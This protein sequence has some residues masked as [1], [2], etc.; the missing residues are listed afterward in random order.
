MTSHRFYHYWL[1]IDGFSKLV[2]DSWNE[3]PVDISN[4]IRNFMKKLHYLKNKIQEWN[5]ANKSSSVNEMT[6]L[7]KDLHI[8]DEVIDNGKGSEAIISKRL[9]VIDSIQR[10]NQRSSAELAQK[11]KIQWSVEGDENS[12][13]FHG[14][15][16]KKRSQMSIRGVMTD[17]VWIDNPELVKREFLH[18]FSNRF[19]EPSNR[20]MHLDMS[21]PCSISLEQQEGLEA[22]VT[23]EEL[24]RA[25]WDC[26]VN[27][28]PGPDGFTFGFYRHFWSLI[29]NDVFEAIKYFFMNGEIPNGCNSSFIALIPKVPDANLVKDFRPIS[30]IGSVYKIIA[31]ILANRLVNVLDGIVSEVH[32]A[33]VTGRQMLDGPFIINELIQWCRSKKRKAVIFKVDF[34]KAFDSVRWD[35]LDDVLFKF[36]F[37][38]KWRA[39]IRN[40]LSSSRGSIL[41]NGSP[42]KEFQFFKGL[43]QGDPLSPFLFI[44][45]MESLHLSFQRVIDA[46]MFTGIK[47]SNS[48][49]V[50]HL[51]FADDAVFVGKW[52]QGNINTLVNVLE[53]FHRASGLKI[54]MSKS[55]LMG[56]HV[57]D[58]LIKQ[59]AVKLGCLT[60]RA[61]FTYLG[62][63]VGGSMSRISEWND[64]VDKVKARLSK[65]KLKTLSIGGRLTVH[66]AVPC[67]RKA[68]WIKWSSVVTPKEK[69]G[70]G[71]AS[72]YAL[73]RGLMLKWL[74]RFYTYPNSIWARVVKAIHGEDGCVGK[75]LKAGARSCWLNIVN[76]AS[77][78]K[79]HG[80][81]FFEFLKPKL[82]DGDK[83]SFWDDKWCEVGLPGVFFAWYAWALDGT[84]E[85]SVSSIRHLIDVTRSSTVSSRTR[86][87]K[88]MPI[89]LNVFAW[90][91]KLNALP[92]RFNISRRGM[93]ISSL[94]C[95]LCQ[96]GC[97]FFTFFRL[98]SLE[99]RQLFS[100]IARS[101]MMLEGV[102]IYLYGGHILV[103]YSQK[104]PLDCNPPFKA[105]LFD[106]I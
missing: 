40:C 19:A 90:K 96:Q 26:G 37:G 82:G 64:V 48:V 57:E 54:N 105:K 92:T 85:F 56:I 32:S 88:Y 28:S 100:K 75:E 31:K 101:N 22:M 73:N 39:W 59:A 14:M 29:E 6:K 55:K 44:L 11:A 67:H 84:G 52:C 70:L 1:E 93:D 83:F 27:K 78:L 3:A 60:F 10:I 87:V 63:K 86:W 72:L 12:K 66:N 20:S 30:L 99:F 97:V 45:V 79:E 36:G 74:W 46:G 53:C 95:P 38:S 21:F 50:S 91:V 58:S 16:N 68:S 69:G 81:N 25:V 17:G 51:F 41:T 76:E 34:E 5:Y 47:L 106:D 80:V 89:K 15:L 9:E 103:R 43:K 2:N 49:T 13:F 23:R 94:S 98:L 65:W 4:G 33:F 24:K 61:P 71:V 42:T 8:L 7:K 102:I 35:Y 18:H 104:D 77:I 62:L